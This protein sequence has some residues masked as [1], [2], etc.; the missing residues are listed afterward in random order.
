MSSVELWEFLQALKDHVEVEAGGVWTAG[1]FTISDFERFVE[2]TEQVLGWRWNRGA[3]EDEEDEQ[4]GPDGSSWVVL[5]KAQ[6]FQDFLNSPEVWQ[7]NCPDDDVLYS[8]YR[9]ILAQVTRPR[10]IKELFQKLDVD[11]CQVLGSKPL[12]HFAKLYGFKGDEREWAKELE[13][14]RARF[15][16]GANGAAKG[17]LAALVS[18]RDPG[19]AAPCYF[20]SSMR[21]DYILALLEEHPPS[22]GDSR[23]VSMKPFVYPASPYTPFSV[24]AALLP[25]GE[26]PLGGHR[27][28]APRSGPC[29]AC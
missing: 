22:L 15:H 25:E 17:H 29:A 23:Q 28:L 11:R 6:Q 18:T 5:I 10:L 26:P 3:T 8:Y 13:D 4:R 21:L 2:C 9:G 19:K 27:G 20:C 7:G 24:L 16:W 1:P 12:L 14:L